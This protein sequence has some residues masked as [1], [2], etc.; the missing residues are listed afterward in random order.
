MGI[1]RDFGMKQCLLMG[2]L[3]RDPVFDSRA[4]HPVGVDMD[5]SRQASGSLAS[6]HVAEQPV[7]ASHEAHILTPES[8]APVYQ[9]SPDAAAGAF[10]YDLDRVVN[11]SSAHGTAACRGPLSQP[12]IEGGCPTHENLDQQRRWLS[13]AWSR[14]AC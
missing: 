10:E 6:R 11:W 13:V 14:D 1:R 2:P 12:M 5:R 8:H 3:A 4:I 7:A 9:C